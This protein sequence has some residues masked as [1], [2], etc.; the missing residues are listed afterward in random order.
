LILGFEVD[1]I[2]WHVKICG[3]VE[4]GQTLKHN[5]LDAVGVAFKAARNLR[6]QRR[7]LRQW[8]EA[9]HVEQ[10]AAQLGLLFLPIVQ[11]ADVAQT[12]RCPIGSKLLQLVGSHFVALR[13]SVLGHKMPRHEKHEDEDASNVRGCGFHGRT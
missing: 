3:D 8:I 2:D 9:K 7:A 10:L 5:F 6:F 4:A 11:R 12:L 1:C 13:L